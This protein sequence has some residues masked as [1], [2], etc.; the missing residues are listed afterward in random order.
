MKNSPK[1]LKKI[2]CGTIIEMCCATAS[3]KNYKIVQKNVSENAETL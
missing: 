1:N 2:A 3:T